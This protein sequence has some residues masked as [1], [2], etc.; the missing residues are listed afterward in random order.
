MRNGHEGA[1]PVILGALRA[2]GAQSALEMARRCGVPPA[3]V[4][5]WAMGEA[6]AGRLRFD[7]E[8]GRFSLSPSGDE[9]LP[10]LNQETTRHGA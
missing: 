3:A 1:A 9:P 4:R 7:P 2:W 6:A 10:F 5:A 8:T